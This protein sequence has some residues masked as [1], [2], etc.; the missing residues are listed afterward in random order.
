MSLKQKQIMTAIDVFV[1]VIL[2]WFVTQVTKAYIGIAYHEVP[3]TS[4]AKLITLPNLFGLITSFIIGPLAAKTNKVKLTMF[5]HVSVIIYS[6]IFFFTGKFHGPFVLLSIACVFAGFAQGAYVPLL[7]SIISDHFPAEDRD[8][9]IANYNVWV[10]VGTLIILQVAGF[11]AAGNDGANWYNAYLLCILTVIGLIIFTV[12]MKKNDAN[13]PSIV[14]VDPDAPKPSFKDIPKDAWVWLIIMGLIH[15][16]FYLA[17]YAFNTQVSSYIITEYKLGTSVQAGTATS[18][19]RIGLIVFTSL[20]PVFKKFLKD[21]MIPVGYIT[22]GV[23]LFIMMTTK[24]LFGA[25]ACGIIA[26]AAT[27]LAHSTLLGK[28][29]RYVPLAMVPV[30]M[31]VIWGI[32]NIGTS[33]AVTLLGAIASLFGGDMRGRFIAG[34]ICSVVAA[35]AAVFM[36]VVK[37]PGKNV[38]LG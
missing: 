18:C 7:N 8:K 2:M 26:G 33:T 12:L 5:A 28:A 38:D 3:E 37:K 21:W 35:V 19:Y 1:A 9:R 16:V 15:C 10:S 31:S 22:M 20:Y 25:Y 30:A 11:L 4:V 6:L 23:G 36:Y 17:Q 34:M 29:S 32:A 13:T 27:S 14:A 24:S